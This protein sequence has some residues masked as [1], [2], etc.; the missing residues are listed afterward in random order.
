MKSKIYTLSVLM[1]LMFNVS[2]SQKGKVKS[3]LNNYDKLSY[4]KSK[5]QLALL[6]EQKDK[7]PEIIEKLANSS[8][9]IG[10]MEDASKWY[11]KLVEMNPNVEPENYFRYAQALKSQE[12]YKEANSILKTFYNIKSNDSRAKQ[13]FNSPEY[14]KVIKEL[15]NSFE[16]VNLDIN[17]PYS[18]FG[19][20]T[21]SGNLVFASSRDKKGK[22][23]NWNQ[24]PF[25]NLFKLDTEGNINGMNGDINTKYHESSTAFTKDGKT[26]YFTRNNFFDGKFKKN[27]K[28]IH[29]LKIYKAT[30]DEGKWV[31]VRP[32]PFNDDEYSVAHPTLSADEKQLYFASDMPGTFGDSDIFV[33][34]IN[35]NGTYGTPVNLGPKVNTEGREN[36]PYVS[37]KSILYFSS[38]GHL[39][40]GGLDVFKI[41][42]N[43]IDGQNAIQNLGKPING[44][45]DDFAYIV[46][47]VSGK[48]Y[49]SSNRPGGKGDDDI[50]SFEMKVCS[51]TVLG[52][53]IDKQTK[54]ILPNT[55]VVVYNSGKNILE[56]LKSDSNG[57]FKFSIPCNSREYNIEGSKDNYNND[58]KNLIVSDEDES[59]L[60]LELELM[61]ESARIGVDLAYILKLQPI[62][63]DYDKSNIRPDAELELAK[64]IDYMTKFPGVKIDVKSHTDSR[65][66]DAYNLALSERRN[67]STIQYIIE[68]GGIS[69][70]RL[71]GRGYGESQ[72]VNRCSNT[73]LLPCSDAEHEENRRSEFIVLEN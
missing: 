37:D 22:I 11:A 70:D 15:S 30:I 32:L 26:V 3:T 45:K 39:G 1:I 36:F 7:S 61:P 23:Y 12:K 69:G 10:E 51:K 34:D 54:E 29:A 49:I 21:H 2:F 62:Y 4:V 66:N 53:A 72:L 58:I 59:V 8:Y 63:F 17:T 50:Y 24:Q 27:S 57:E 47:E 44:P 40:L 48:G 71:T 31:N 55:N 68:K 38:D 18:D 5:K 14:L 35:D 60:K 28:K 6:A 13:F 9:F 41:E 46:D 56:T 42:I 20:S 43:K 52:K 16:L 73:N 33:V 67:K 65:A 19:T 64:V 25:L